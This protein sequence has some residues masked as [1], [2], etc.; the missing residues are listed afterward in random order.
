VRGEAYRVEDCRPLTDWTPGQD[1]DP[2][3]AHASVRVDALEA[4][5]G[6]GG[7]GCEVDCGQ[8]GLHLDILRYRRPLWSREEGR[9]CVDGAVTALSRSAG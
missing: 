4:L 6:G 5:Q 8:E 3:R 1:V 7:S 9:A 2:A